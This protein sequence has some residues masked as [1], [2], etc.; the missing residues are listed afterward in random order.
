MTD[1]LKL[2]K[3]PDAVFCYND[4]TAVGAIR[5]LRGIAACSR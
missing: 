3:I 1:L 2:N 4:L 5:C